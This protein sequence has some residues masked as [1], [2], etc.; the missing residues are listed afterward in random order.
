MIGRACHTL[1]WPA[2]AKENGSQEGGGGA[3]EQQEHTNASEAARTCAA[4][5][6]TSAA[7]SPAPSS[8]S[9]PPGVCCGGWVVRHAAE[10]RGGVSLTQGPCQE[11]GLGVTPP[12]PPVPQAPYVAKSSRLLPP[13]PLACGLGDRWDAHSYTQACTLTHTR[14][15]T[16]TRTHTH[17]HTRTRTHAHAHAHTHAHTHSPGAA[18]AVPSLRASPCARPPHHHPPPPPCPLPPAPCRLWVVAPVE[19]RGW[20]VPKER[21]SAATCTHTC[22]ICPTHASPGIHAPWQHM[23]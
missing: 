3:R 5:S 1:S 13:S 7:S 19:G 2:L 8:P 12:S 16:H 6:A 11:E 9:W 21:I 23:S 18:R 17:T 14:A 4:A 22:S 20:R 15:R 10:V